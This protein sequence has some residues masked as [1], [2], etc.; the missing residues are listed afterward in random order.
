MSA[1]TNDPERWGEVALE[2]GLALVPGIG[3]SRA[4]VAGEQF[5]VRR[6]RVKQ[7]GSDLIAEHPAEEVIG[8]L[9][10]DERFGEVFLRAATAV[11]VTHWE[12]KRKAMGRVVGQALGDD[13]AVDESEMLLLA[14]EELGAPHF[15]AL[16]RLADT[17]AQQRETKG[18]VEAIQVPGLTAPVLAALLGV[19]AVSQV[20]GL[21]G[22]LHRPTGFGLRLLNL[23]K[24]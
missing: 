3:G 1:E 2:A 6:R 19:G 7:L 8:R 18:A 17:A 12:P 16:A 10:A 11:A 21:G 5:E 4:V 14:L 20:S 23:V 22:L 13:A 15:A 24:L 9:R